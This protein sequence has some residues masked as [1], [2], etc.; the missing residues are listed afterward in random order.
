MEKPTS[1]DYLHFIKV[2]QNSMER[3]VGDRD[4]IPHPA[5]ESH[6]KVVLW[7]DAQM[8]APKAPSSQEILEFLDRV[9]L[10]VRVANVHSVAGY[11]VTDAHYKVQSWLEDYAHYLANIDNPK[12]EK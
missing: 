3:I 5:Y 10:A 2:T 11:H 7:L 12:M 4:Y 9:H 1:L 6:K 8:G